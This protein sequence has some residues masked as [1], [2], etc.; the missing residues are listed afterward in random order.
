LTSTCRPDGHANF[1]KFAAVVIVA[2]RTDH[3]TDEADLMQ[4]RAWA[5]WARAQRRGPMSLMRL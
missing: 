2:S 1:W 5:G 4:I 3:Q